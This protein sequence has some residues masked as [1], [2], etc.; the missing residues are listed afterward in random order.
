VCLNQHHWLAHHLQAEGIS[1]RQYGNA[2]LTCSDPIR[3][4]ALAD[5]LTPRDLAR[6]AQKWLRTFTPFLTPT[7]RREAACQH[8]LFL[9][10]VEYCDNLIFQRRAALDALGE[11]LFDA[12]CTIGQ[13][14]KLA[15]IF[16]RKV[17][18]RHRGNS[19]PSSKILTCPIR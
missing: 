6:C 15:T 4:Q 19:K 2:F 18:K 7:E 13:P 5:A 1:F 11:R 9:A 3:L 17:T 12:N 8:R 10:Q 16:G 14:T